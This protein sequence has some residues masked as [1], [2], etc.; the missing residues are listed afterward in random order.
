MADVQGFLFFDLDGTIADS[1]VDICTAMNEV[2]SEMGVAE[3]NDIEKAHLVGPPL[4]D[5]L[6][7]IMQPRNINVAHLQEI[8]DRYRQIYKAKYL[9]HTRAITGMSDVV[10]QLHAERF[11]LSVVT[12]KPQPQAGVAL[13]ATGLMDC[14]VTVVGPRENQPTPKDQLLRIAMNDVASRLH[15]AVA[16]E[17]SWMIGDRHFD[18]NAAHAVGAT[19]V[20]VMW[21]HGDHDEFVAAEAHHIVH[22]PTELLHV[23]S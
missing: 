20:G 2:L 12:T 6:P 14:F 18:I 19:S 5:A 1:G 7:P 10:R 23:I 16:V 4:Q 13:R 21:G 11:V 9:P 17:Q 3:L 22:T 15:Q 8:I